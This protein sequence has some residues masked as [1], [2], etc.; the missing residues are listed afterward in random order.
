MR[1]GPSAL[2]RRQVV[3]ALA[4]NDSNAI[5]SPFN[6][7]EWPSHHPQPARR[8]P[9]PPAAARGASGRSM[10]A[11]VHDTVARASLEPSESPDADELQDWVDRLYGGH[12]PEKVV[13]EPFP[14]SALNARLLSALSVRR[15]RRRADRRQDGSADPRSWSTVVADRSAASAAVR[16]DGSRWHANVTHGAGHGV[17]P[18]VASV[19]GI[20]SPW[21]NSRGISTARAAVRCGRRCSPVHF[22]RSHNSA[23]CAA[24]DKMRSI[25]THYE[26]EE[27]TPW[28]KPS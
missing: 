8:G 10:E 25:N 15:S 3:R 9:R 7:K 2:P 5:I 26:R 4:V 23:H 27:K 12:R 11:E 28:P 16:R 13:D 6:P 17:A 19:H 21:A 24:V 1:L 22:P 14:P 18:W 20:W